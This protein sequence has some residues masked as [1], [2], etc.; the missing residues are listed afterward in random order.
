MLDRK[1]RTGLLVAVQKPYLQ[2]FYFWR[3]S[4]VYPTF[5]WIRKPVPPA[6]SIAYSAFIALLTDVERITER[7]VAETL[8]EKTYLSNA[9][10]KLSPVPRW[11]ELKPTIKPTR[12]QNERGFLLLELDQKRK[13][14]VPDEVCLVA[15]SAGYDVAELQLVGLRDGVQV[16]PV[17]TLE[18][19]GELSL[20][21]RSEDKNKLLRFENLQLKKNQTVQLLLIARAPEH[22]NQELNGKL[23]LSSSTRTKQEL[24]V[25]LRVYRIRRP[26]RRLM[27]LKLYGGTLYMLSGGLKLDDESSIRRLEFYC[28]DAGELGATV[29]QVYA[30]LNLLLRKLRVRQTGKPLTQ[31][32]KTKPE[33]FRTPEG[34]KAH[35]DFS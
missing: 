30:P 9:Q 12:A 13:V 19:S 11:R 1:T 23:A 21:I 17:L 15:P 14:R 34:P 32:I 5:E 4:K 33:L 28:R 8:T 2:K 3:G 22:S 29:A 7:L 6:N 27:Y 24:K 16:K 10:R 35:I 26:D 31:A 25:R 20:Y 18:N